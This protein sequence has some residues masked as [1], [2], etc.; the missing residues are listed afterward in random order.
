MCRTSFDLA[1]SVKN[2][3]LE[4]LERTMVEIDVVKYTA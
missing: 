3:V 2:H 1:E 4:M